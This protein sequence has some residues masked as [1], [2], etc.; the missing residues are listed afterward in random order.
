MLGAAGVA[1]RRAAEALIRAGRV[2]VNGR[3]VT[4]LGVR[5][6]P[7]HDR[8]AVDGRPIRPPQPHVHLAFHKPVGVVTTLDDPEARASIADFVRRLKQ[9][10]FPVGRLDVQS[11]GLLLLTNDGELALR[12][13]HPRYHVAKTYRVKVHGRPEERVLNRLRDGVRLD[14]GVT[15]PAEV[16]VLEEVGRKTWLEVTIG[17]G[18]NRQI[19]R[20]CEAVGLP[21]DK[22][23]R[24]RIGP[25]K[26]GNLPPGH[27]RPL[28][29]AEL[30]A[31]RRQVGL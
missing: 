16:R 23:Q 30:A 8:I 21:V 22:L 12:L 24:V 11:S 26:L 3:T 6:D 29:D 31:L 13:T 14:D 5:A 9:R 7:R 20:M 18:R 25:L 2:S 19:R 1:S 17:E 15:A 27:W 10:V 4:E 28:A